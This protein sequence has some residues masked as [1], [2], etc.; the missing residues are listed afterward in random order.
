[1]RK[2]TRL[3]VLKTGWGLGTRLKWAVLLNENVQ[4]QQIS[5]QSKFPCS[6]LNLTG[7]V[8]YSVHT[9]ATVNPFKWIPLSASLA[10]PNTIK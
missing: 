7:H 3:S 2:D 6:M 5:V 8:V 10:T 1:M 9:T 4:K